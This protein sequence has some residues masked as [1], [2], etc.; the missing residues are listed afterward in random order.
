MKPH[1]V[2]LF[3]LLFVFCFLNKKIYRE[4]IKKIFCVKILLKLLTFGKDRTAL[5]RFRRALAFEIISTVNFE[6][7]IILQKIFFLISS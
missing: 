3:S 2:I 7:N 1:F 5:R 6:H 4:K